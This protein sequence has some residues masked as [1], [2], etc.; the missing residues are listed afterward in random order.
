MSETTEQHILT[1]MK[2]WERFLL[3][4]GGLYFVYKFVLFKE[5]SRMTENPLVLIFTSIGLLLWMVTP[6]KVG[7]LSKRHIHDRI[8]ASALIFFFLA[9]VVA[10]MKYNPFQPG[11]GY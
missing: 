7:L 5:M 11:Y 4:A 8:W 1:K 6:F 9:L 3:W 10:T 2:W